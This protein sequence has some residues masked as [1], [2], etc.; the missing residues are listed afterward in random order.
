MLIV[1]DDII[2][3]V[4]TNKKSNPIVTELI[5][6]V[7]KYNISLVFMLQSIIKR[8]LVRK[9]IQSITTSNKTKLKM[10]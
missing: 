7:R 4:E 9:L 10:I 8:L 5:L 2:A 6:R 1:F 3:D